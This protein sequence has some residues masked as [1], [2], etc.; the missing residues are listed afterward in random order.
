MIIRLLRVRK[1]ILLLPEEKVTWLEMDKYAIWER[2]DVHVPFFMYS[3]K[4]VFWAWFSQLLKYK[5][6]TTDTELARKLI[7]RELWAVRWST[8][9]VRSFDSFGEETKNNWLTRPFFI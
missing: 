7:S 1:N 8:I 4:I 5:L 9:V 2:Q 6:P 3:N